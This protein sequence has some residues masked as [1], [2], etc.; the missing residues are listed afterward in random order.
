MQF[1]R[2]KNNSTMIPRNIPIIFEG[3]AT[4]C[5]HRLKK[6]NDPGERLTNDQRAAKRN[7]FTPSEIFQ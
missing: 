4:F 7:I 5:C 2:R 1:P 3:K 6:K